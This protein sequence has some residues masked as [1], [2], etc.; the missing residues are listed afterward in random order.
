[1]EPQRPI[2]HAVYQSGGVDDNGYPV[3][4][5]YGD[6][7]E[8]FIYGIQPI[9]SEVPVGNDE[10]AQRIINSRLL[11]VPDT[12]VF[13]PGDRVAWGSADINDDESAYR[14]SQDVQ[15]MSLGPWPDFKPSTEADAFGAVVVER[16]RG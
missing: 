1:M 16:V 2:R 13:N 15:D 8:R 3:P 9:S 7:A 5:G 11:L 14:V 10:L 6:P 12:A 4:E